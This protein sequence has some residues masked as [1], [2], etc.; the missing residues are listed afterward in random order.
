MTRFNRGLWLSA[1]ASVDVRDFGL[2]DNDTP[3]AG[4]RRLHHGR[5]LR[6]RQGLSPGAQD[7][8]L[9]VYGLERT[10]RRPRRPARRS[11]TRP[12]ASAPAAPTRS[13]RRR[14]ATTSATRP[15]ASA[16]AKCTANSCPS[17]FT[18]DT[19]SGNCDASGTRTRG[20][21][22][23]TDAGVACNSANQPD[24]CGYGNY[25]GGDNFCGAIVNGTCSNVARP[26]GV[27]TRR[28]RAR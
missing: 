3:D 23:G 6:H 15:P 7:V 26:P 11:T 4:Q 1:A 21:D 16:R 18:C 19:A 13:A 17:G 24:V 5:D 14:S 20:T 22:A 9:D 27:E 10:A 12:Q 8:R 28:P 25:C 2:R